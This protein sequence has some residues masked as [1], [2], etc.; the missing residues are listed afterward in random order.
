VI[1]RI[2]GASLA[3]SDGGWREALQI[4]VERSLRSNSLLEMVSSIIGESHPPTSWAAV[5]ATRRWHLDGAPAE[6]RI[7]PGCLAEPGIQ[8]ESAPSALFG[9]GL[10]FHRRQR[11]PSC[12]LAPLL[13]VLS[14]S[15]PAQRDTELHGRPVGVEVDQLELAREEVPEGVCRPLQRVASTHGVGNLRGSP[16]DQSMCLTCPVQRSFGLDITRLRLVRPRAVY[17]GARAGRLT[18]GAG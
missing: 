4:H 5:F 16:E 13:Y 9:D 7:L 3:L 2:E 15:P 14:G 17:I 12:E 10:R 8:T 18:K 11:E 6:L 1:C